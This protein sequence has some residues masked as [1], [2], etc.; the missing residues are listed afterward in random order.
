MHQQNNAIH[1]TSNLSNTLVRSSPKKLGAVTPPRKLWSSMENLSSKKLLDSDDSDEYEKSHIILMGIIHHHRHHNIDPSRHVRWCK[2]IRTILIPTISEF[3][4][5]H[6]DD[7]IWWQSDD[8][9]HFQKSAE[10]EIENLMNIYHLE[11]QRAKQLIYQPN[12]EDILSNLSQ[13]MSIS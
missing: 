6:L 5:A 7:K 3:R 10:S 13:K 9:D 2:E 4:A 12:Y 11:G 8:Y 1:T